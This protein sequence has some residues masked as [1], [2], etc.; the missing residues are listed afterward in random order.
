MLTASPA[1]VAFRHELARLAV[2]ESLAPNRRVALHRKALAALAD[3][4]CGAPELARLAH[5]AEAAGDREAVLEFAPKAAA[6]AA[7]LGAHREAAAQ[8]ARA[9]RFAEDQ[10]L[11]ARAELLRCRSNECYLTDEADEAIG[12]IE[13]AIECYRGSATGSA[14]G[15][16]CAALE[17]LWCPGRARRRRKP[18][19]RPWLC[20]SSFRPGTSSRWRT[21]TFGSS[22]AAP[23]TSKEPCSGAPGR[24]S[25]RS[26]STTPR[27]SAMPSP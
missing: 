14:R 9:L 17:D 6:R 4:P 18:A 8:Y 22:A 25:S 21:A 1:D 12:A 27:Y 23:T 5:H 15:T 13:G 20:W 24:S 16:F 3:S 26:A 19:R 11:E 2:E 10:P 7:S